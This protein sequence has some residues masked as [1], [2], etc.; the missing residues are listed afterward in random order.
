MSDT[1]QFRHFDYVLP[2][3][4]LAAGEQKRLPLQIDTDSSFILRG[5]ALHI[6]TDVAGYAGQLYV[7]VP[8]DGTATL[9]INTTGAMVWV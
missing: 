7:Q 9:W 4:S 2:I 1:F 6:R 3:A 5:R 8:G